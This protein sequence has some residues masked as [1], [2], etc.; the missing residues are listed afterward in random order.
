MLMN[1]SLYSTT[2]LTAE[3]IGYPAINLN[4]YEFA[5]YQKEKLAENLSQVNYYKRLMADPLYAQ[6]KANPPEGYTSWEKYA[7]DQGALNAT[8]MHDG[9]LLKAHRGLNMGPDEGLFLG[10]S[11]EGVLSRRG[12]SA[13]GR[14]NFERVNRGEKI[15][16][17]KTESHYYDSLIKIEGN[18]NVYDERSLRVFAKDIERILEDRSRR[19]VTRGSNSILVQ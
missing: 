19:K 13:L 12:M 2:P 9:G 5:A 16:T 10:L 15:E 3:Q 11:D 8:T 7:Q 4:E 17:S 6:M 18:N 14:D 1:P